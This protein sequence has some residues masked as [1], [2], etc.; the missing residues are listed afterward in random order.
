[1]KKKN[2]TRAS[3]LWSSQS[4][5]I[6]KLGIYCYGCKNKCD[7]AKTI[8]PWAPSFRTLFHYIKT[9]N[10]VMFLNNFCK[11]F[12]CYTIVIM[13]IFNYFFAIIF[14][15]IY[16]FWLA[17]ATFIGLLNPHKWNVCV[18]FLAVVYQSTSRLCNIIFH[19]LKFFQ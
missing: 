3:Y 7:F 13:P 10:I 9:Q 12:K 19:L 5:S 8:K 6:K 14:L 2:L 15:F 4:D 17:S 1:M 16:R 18:L 11:F